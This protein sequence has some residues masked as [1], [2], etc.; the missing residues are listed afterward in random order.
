MK[1]VDVE[2]AEPMVPDA[3]VAVYARKMRVVD[4]WVVFSLGVFTSLFSIYTSVASTAFMWTIWAAVETHDAIA[5]GLM[6]YGDHSTADVLRIASAVACS[7]GY[8]SLLLSFASYEELLGEVRSTDRGHVALAMGLR[9][10]AS[11]PDFY[12][13]DMVRV[14]ALGVVTVLLAANANGFVTSVAWT[15]WTV[16]Q[17]VY[18]WYPLNGGGTTPSAE[19]T[20]IVSLFS[21]CMCQIFYVHFIMKTMH[22]ATSIGDM[23]SGSVAHT[24]RVNAVLALLLHYLV[25]LLA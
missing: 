8:V 6:A 13:A 4:M 11:I 25:L 17:T 12:A 1:T 16:A 23:G 15:M 21:A 5:L 19:F 9:A 10:A 2:S 7:A 14:F 18:A 22:T 20:R 3:D 24:D